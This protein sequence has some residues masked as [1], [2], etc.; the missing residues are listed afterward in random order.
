[1]KA[2]KKLSM[3]KRKRN[4]FF[5]LFF[6][7]LLTSILI[8][9]LIGCEKPETKETKIPV[10]LYH[11]FSNDSLAKTIVTPAKFER[12]MKFLKS[13]GYT[14]VSL[15]DLKDFLNKKKRLPPKPILITFDDGWESQYVVARPIL[16]KYKM[17]AAL[18]P[19]AGQIGESGYLTWTQLREMLDSHYF[20]LGSKSF[21]LGQKSPGI[22]ATGGVSFTFDDGWASVYTEAFPVLQK[23][24][25]KATVFP[26][27]KVL[28]ESMDNYM[29][30]AQVN[31]LNEA[32]WEI[33]SHGITHRDLNTLSPE[34]MKE[35]LVESQKYLVAQGFSA[36]NL[37]LPEGAH[38]EQVLAEA[39]RYYTYIRGSEKGFNSFPL[40]FPLK[41]QFL[42]NTTT[43][44]E[45]TSW[46]DEAR[47]DKKWLLLQFH[48]V[49]TAQREY[50][51]S[52]E[53][54]SRI[55]DYVS[56]S[57]L[58][59]TLIED[60]EGRFLILPQP[61]DGSLEGKKAYR[62][63]LAKDFKKSREVFKNEAGIV[64]EYVAY[65]YGIWNNDV[66]A[67]LKK[68]GF[69]GAF[70]GRAGVNRQEENPFLLKRILVEEKTDLKEALSN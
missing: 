67:S 45:V 55:V 17:Q 57:G 69:G 59:I 35:E 65:P 44:E 4:Y 42:T 25:L 53:L 24:G 1:M 29:T 37:A 56:S 14:A 18:F 27:V 60:V 19:F 12:D 50:A 11:Q 61:R 62:L 30:L 40:T 21:A 28:K 33:G 31:E 23:K 38:N 6:L 16:R 39:K 47:R 5:T 41:S 63:R 2:N 48:Q 13:R 66:I 49:D 34:E 58:P 22:W 64:P 10:L 7:L 51:T 54:F 8:T 26:L 3:R 52:P 70:T 36:E 20:E 9:T 43:F 46:V 15:K 68:T 32:G